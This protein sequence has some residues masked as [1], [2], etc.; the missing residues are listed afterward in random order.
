MLAW[1]QTLSRGAAGF[2]FLNMSEKRE[3][4]QNHDSS[5]RD[6]SHFTEEATDTTQT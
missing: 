3:T 1:E 4:W 2:L 5:S 6:T